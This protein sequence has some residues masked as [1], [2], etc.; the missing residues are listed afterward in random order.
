MSAAPVDPAAVAAL[1]DRY[2][3][4]WS[5]PDPARRRALLADVLTQ[6]ATYT[7]PRVHA[8]SPGALAL[9]IDRVLAERPGARVLRTSGV[10]VHHGMAR[11]AW[12]VV[13]A[14][15]STLPEGIDVVWLNADGTRLERI[16]GFFGP[17]PRPGE[18]DTARKP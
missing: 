3:L 9:H 10:D 7:D 16:V 14:D 12:H 17:L 2:A 18:A 8:E 11:F 5:D 1:V 4:A 6:G 13:Q 15:G